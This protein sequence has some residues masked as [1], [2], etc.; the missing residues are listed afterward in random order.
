M[1]VFASASAAKDRIKTLDISHSQQK[2]H[3]EIRESYNRACVFCVNFSTVKSS[4][5]LYCHSILTIEV[6]NSK[7]Q[8]GENVSEKLKK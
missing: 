6:S 2:G 5:F 3:I 8:I 1:V 4:F 7:S